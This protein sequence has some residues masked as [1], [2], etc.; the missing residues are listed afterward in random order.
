MIGLPIPVKNTQK[1]GKS[2]FVPISTVNVLKLND[3]FASYAAS[4]F[5]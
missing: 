2:P 3:T 4:S 1:K 5:R